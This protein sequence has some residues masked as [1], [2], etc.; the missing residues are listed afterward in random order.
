VLKHVKKDII[1]GMGQQQL[2][3]SATLLKVGIMVVRTLRTLADTFYV[4]LENI[5]Q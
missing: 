4:N 2:L 3:C 1:V 5:V